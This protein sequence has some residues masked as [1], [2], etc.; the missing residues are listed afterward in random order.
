M[1]KNNLVVSIEEFKSHLYLDGIETND[2]LLFMYLKAAEEYCNAYN[3]VKTSYTK[4]NAPQG[5]KL[6]ILMLASSYFFN[7][8]ATTERMDKSLT[9]G[10]KA[11]L[12]MHRERFSV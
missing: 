2:N 6:A 10:V 12:N 1:D 9:F 5:V 7:K 3:E 8:E 4:E 11:L